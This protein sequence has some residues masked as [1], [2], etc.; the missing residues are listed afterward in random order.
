MP[1]ARMGK[2]QGQASIER[3]GPD[4]I[5]NLREHSQ[6]ENF[7]HFFMAEPPEYPS[8]QSEVRISAG[9]VF[10]EREPQPRACLS[11]SHRD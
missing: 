2:L 3:Y 9:P 4:L 5:L 6:L 8:M 11:D 10:R 7:S 1:M